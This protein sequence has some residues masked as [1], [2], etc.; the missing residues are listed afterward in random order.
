MRT[1]AVD[2][3]RIV[4]ADAVVRRDPHPAPVETANHLAV[5]AVAAGVVML[6]RHAHRVRL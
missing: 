3:T 1:A 5:V 6:D 2:R 4:A